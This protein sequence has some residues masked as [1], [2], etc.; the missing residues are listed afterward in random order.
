[1]P[2]ARGDNAPVGGSNYRL[3]SQ[4]M[5]AAGFADVGSVGRARKPGEENE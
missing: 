4:E 2:L 1:L 5:L 3:A